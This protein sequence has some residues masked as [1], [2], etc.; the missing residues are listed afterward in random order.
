MP[1]V[2]RAL[3]VGGLALTL[4]LAL[5]LFVRPDFWWAP[6]NPAAAPWWAA[7]GAILAAAWR[8]KGAL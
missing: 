2:F 8:P 6:Y 7:G 1:G 5:T 3:A 4:A